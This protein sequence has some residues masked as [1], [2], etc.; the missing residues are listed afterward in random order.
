MTRPIRLG[1]NIDHVATL[2]QVRGTPYPDPVR[3]ALEAESAG[4]D[5]IT[6]HLREDRR[7]IQD[8]DVF[9][10][11]PLLKTRMNLEAALTRE[12]LQIAIKARPHDVCLVPERR[13]EL[14]TEGGLDVVGQFERVR[15]A[16]RLLGEAGIRV[17][18][19]ISHDPRQIEAA[20]ATGAPVIEIHTGHYADLMGVQADAEFKRITAGV[21]LGTRLGL[22]VNAGHGLHY[23]NTARIAAIPGIEELNIG[24]AIVAES[25]F[26]GWHAAVADMKALMVAARASALP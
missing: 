7:H 4:A 10:L 14:T 1:V 13:M 18:L 8:R 19:F 2:R 6:L 17:S 23:G 9:E 25:V 3:A 20:H 24:H 5:L 16:V 11:R 15:D 22:T 21:D 26:R 12:M